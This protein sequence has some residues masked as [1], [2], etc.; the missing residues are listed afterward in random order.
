M[1]LV[2]RNSYNNIVVY[3]VCVKIQLY[4]MYIRSERERGST[5]LLM[6]LSVRLYLRIFSTTINRRMFEHSKHS[7][8]RYAIW[9]DK[10]LNL[11]IRRHLPV[12]W[13]LCFLWIIQNIGITSEH[14]SWSAIRS[15]FVI[16]IKIICYLGN[17]LINKKNQRIIFII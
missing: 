15:L 4:Y 17:V 7:L 8:L 3:V 14:W 9:W 6:C 5:V 10:L 13:R 1:Y 2:K 12:K 11:S 16:Y